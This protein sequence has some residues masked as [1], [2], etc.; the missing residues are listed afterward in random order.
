MK[1]R[2]F[3]YLNL[4]FK[5]YI[6]PHYKVDVL[7]DKFNIIKPEN[8]Y[9]ELVS[10]FGINDDELF[11]IYYQWF[12]DKTVSLNNDIGDACYQLPFYWSSISNCLLRYEV[13]IME[14]LSDKYITY[15]NLGTNMS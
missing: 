2:I 8:V 5:T 6:G 14:I 15:L 4:Y 10:V 9:L 11:E 7:D 12:E 1:N 3:K 13:N